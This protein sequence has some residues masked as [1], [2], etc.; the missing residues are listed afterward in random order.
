VRV[1]KIEYDARSGG[2]RIQVDGRPFGAIGAG[3]VVDLGL[4]ES[5][6]LDEKTSARL[7]ECAERW[8]A[9]AVALR[10]LAVRSLPER[11]LVR[12]LVRRGHAKPLVEQAV[13][14]LKELGL[15]NDAEFAKAYV[16]TRVKGQRHGPRRMLGDLR[17]LGVNEKVAQKALSETI[18]ADGVDLKTTLREAAAKKARTLSK[19]EPEVARRR[20]RA[21]LVRRGF[22]G[23]EVSSVLRELAAQ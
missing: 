1:T 5:R 13:A 12:R 6:E 22:S 15:V 20:L 14:S 4:S 3:D 8:S 19:L 17:R 21:F 7:V 2:V 16:R 9:R 18:E 11:E 10:I 23:T